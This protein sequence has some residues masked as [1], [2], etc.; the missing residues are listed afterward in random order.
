MLPL[1]SEA[2]TTMVLSQF[3]GAVPP[4]LTAELPAATTTGTLRLTAV[5]MAFCMVQ[6]HSPG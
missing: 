4:A 3:A 1:L 5:L 2:P 6:P